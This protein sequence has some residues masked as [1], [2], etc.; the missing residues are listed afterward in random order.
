MARRI[1]NAMWWSVEVELCGEDGV[2]TDA[3]ERLDAL[4]AAA[5]ATV[6]GSPVE[7]RGRYGARL[8]VEAETPEAAVASALGAFR[9]AAAE[10]GLPAWP[11]VEVECVTEEELERRLARPVVPTLVGV[12]E[13]ARLLARDGVRVSRQRASAVTSR[14]DFPEPVARLASGPIWTRDSVQNFVGTWE[15]RP[16]RPA[17]NEVL[18][19]SKLFAQTLPPTVLL[20]G[21][22]ALVAVGIILLLRRQD[23]VAARLARPDASLP[24]TAPPEA[25]RV[26]DITKRLAERNQVLQVPADVAA[27]VAR[28]S[29]RLAI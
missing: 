17:R 24:P 9:H 18:V 21:L 7:G 23:G 15:R 19:D 11:V 26:L 25:A 20:V 12:S 6:S 10:A 28:R 16:G 4:L 1:V 13:I 29:G 3:L 8:S 22:V 5:A 2:S 27:A 14:T